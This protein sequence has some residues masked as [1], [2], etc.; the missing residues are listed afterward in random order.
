MTGRPG[1]PRRTF[2]VQNKQKQARCQA[3][4]VSGLTMASTE[5]QSRQRR[6]RQTHSKRSPDVNFGRLFADRC[7]TL[8]WWRKARF[9]SSRT[10]R[11]RKIECK[12][13]RSVARRI[14]I[15]RRNYRTKYKSRPLRLFEVFERHSL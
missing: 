1:W 2:Q 9:S 12:A 6:D 15:G 5:R 10:V 14:S 4:T 7:S 3:T 11:D 8:I 13:E